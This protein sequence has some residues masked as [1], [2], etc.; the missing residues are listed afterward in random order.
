MNISL[1]FLKVP[2]LKAGRMFLKKSFC[3][4]KRPQVPEIVPILLTV[5]NF[6]KKGTAVEMIL[7]FLH[8]CWIRFFLKMADDTPRDMT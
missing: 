1:K 7:K 3:S 4:R 2:A 6:P 8:W 5:F